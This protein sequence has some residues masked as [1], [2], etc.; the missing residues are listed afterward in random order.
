MKFGSLRL[1]EFILVGFFFLVKL[2][3]VSKNFFL[4]GGGGPFVAYKGGCRF[5]KW[6]QETDVCEKKTRVHARAKAYNIVGVCVCV[7]LQKIK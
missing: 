4:L 7:S 2:T 3:F 1:R 6:K 5:S